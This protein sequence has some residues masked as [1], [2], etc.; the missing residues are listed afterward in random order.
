MRIKRLLTFAM[1]LSAAAFTYGHNY[2]PSV[3][4]ESVTLIPDIS[5]SRAAYR[6]LTKSGQVD[7]Y[8]FAARKGQ[9]IYVQMTVPLLDRL[10]GFAPDF[11]LVYVGDSPAKFAQPVTEMGKISDPDHAVIDTIHPH[12]G[13]EETEPP[14]IG[15]SYAGSTDVVFDEPVTSTRYWIRQSLTVSA[16]ADG[17]YRIGVFSAD[18]R[19]GKY[20]LAPGKAEKFGIADIL[21]LPKVRATVREFCE[22]PTWPDVLVAVLIGAAVVAGAVAAGVAFL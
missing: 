8:E 14:M 21:S 18:G 10:Q 19:I 22:Q 9:E 13:T 16:P 15:L 1:A 5:V 7:L 2:L 11:V 3:A 20:V 4:G 12:A 6:E 17:T